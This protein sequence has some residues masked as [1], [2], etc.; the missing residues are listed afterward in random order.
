VVSYSYERWNAAMY[1]RSRHKEGRGN[2]SNVQLAEQGSFKLSTLDDRAMMKLKVELEMSTAGVRVSELSPLS[3]CEESS[4]LRIT[5]R[6][7]N[8]SQ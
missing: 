8:T 5:R 6:D 1:N 7:S 3:T 4:R 2:A